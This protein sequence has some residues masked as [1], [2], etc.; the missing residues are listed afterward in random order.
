MTLTTLNL[1]LIAFGFGILLGCLVS[2]FIMRRTI[3]RNMKSLTNVVNMLSSQKAVKEQ[4]YQARKESL[5]LLAHK[6]KQIESNIHKLRR[7]E[8]DKHINGLNRLLDSIGISK[9]NEDN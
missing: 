3:Y 2:Y 7:K 1:T 5:L 9:V 6:L 4:E 8:Y